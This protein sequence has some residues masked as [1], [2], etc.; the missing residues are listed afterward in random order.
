MTTPAIEISNL[1]RHFNNVHAV[2]GIDLTIQQGGVYGVTLNNDIRKGVFDRFRSLPIWQPAVLVGALLGD[3]A[4]YTI[5]S[6]IVII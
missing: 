6:A 4:R 3:A 2:N 5:A 1:T